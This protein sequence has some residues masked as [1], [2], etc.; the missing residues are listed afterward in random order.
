MPYV[1]PPPLKIGSTIGLVTP[2]SPMLPG[3]LEAGIAYLQNKGFKVKLGNHIHETHRFL[4]G[5]D[6][7]RAE[8]IMHFFADKEI[9]AIVATG[10][11]Y[12]SQRILPYLDYELIHNH[13]KWVTGFSDTTA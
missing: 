5:S 4:A 2:S 8:D 6:E 10:G 12:G 9:K 3:R 13:P 1:Y 11:G 7:S